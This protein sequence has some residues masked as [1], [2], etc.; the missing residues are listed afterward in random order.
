[1]F[2]KQTL[3]L[4]KKQ[5]GPVTIRVGDINTLLSLTDRT[6]RQI[7]NKYVLELNNITDE[8]DSTDIG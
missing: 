1:M 6:F 4:I 2:I 8:I 7:I 5:I 3:W